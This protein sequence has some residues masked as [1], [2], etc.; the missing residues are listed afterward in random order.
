MNQKRLFPAVNDEA[1]EL[2]RLV[3]VDLDLNFLLEGKTSFG[4]LW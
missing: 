1:K 4:R 2:T 3:F